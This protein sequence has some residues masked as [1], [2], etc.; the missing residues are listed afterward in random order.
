MVHD[1]GT[2]FVVDLG[3]DAGFADEVDDPFLAFVLVKAEA[4][5]EVP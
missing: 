4:G 2:V 3:V 5:G 1:H